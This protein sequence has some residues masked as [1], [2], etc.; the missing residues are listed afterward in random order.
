MSGGIA[1]AAT[2][3]PNE[4]DP[5]KC[6]SGVEFK[7][8]S[9]SKTSAE[10]REPI[11]FA[12][13][14]RVPKGCTEKALDVY[15]VYHCGTPRKVSGLRGSQ[16]LPALGT[17]TYSL[18]V[19]KGQAYRTLARR[20]ITVNV[21]NPVTIDANDMAPTLT[22]ALGTPGQT[23]NVRNNVDISLTFCERIPVAGGVKLLGGRSPT[24]PGPRIWTRAYPGALLS[25][26]GDDVRISGMRIEG[27]RMD[28]Y[29]GKLLEVYGDSIPGVGRQKID[30]SD[31]IEIGTY[32]EFPIVRGI[33]I[34]NNEIFGWMGSGV[35]VR[36]KA[37][38]LPTEPPYKA[39]VHDNYFHH[40]RRGG[41]DGYGVSVYNGAFVLIDRNV[42]DYNRHAIAGDGRFGSGYA[43]YD[44]VILGNGGEHVYVKGY[45]WRYTH[46]IDMHG[47]DS[48]LGHLN[49]GQ[50]GH[51]MDVQ[52]NAV[53]YARQDAVKLRGTPV[54]PRG[55]LVTN[56]SFTLPERPRSPNLPEAAVQTEKGLR[57]VG[58]EYQV[59][60]TIK[61]CDYDGRGQLDFFMATGRSWWYSIRGAPHWHYMARSRERPPACPPLPRTPV[62]VPVA[63]LSSRE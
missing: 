56:N 57:E 4:S 43:L 28:V 37:S 38:R 51:H 61:R 20:R 5:P 11:T 32:T 7:S 9:A 58:N 41:G 46:Q 33:E 52:H 1:H 26:Q 44:N 6:L 13:D 3:D 16:T 30:L 2:K 36:D 49:C 35:E 17:T 34:D 40:N 25:V 53:F 63:E 39:R 18:I 10:L 27:A 22:H 29:R 59:G 19:R 42:F 62:N 60:P 15:L 21:P 24:E 12:W 50:A 48:C 55:M 31:G 8:F 47:R 54:D 45:G 23:I 14:V